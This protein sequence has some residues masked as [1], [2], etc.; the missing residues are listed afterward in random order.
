M[1]IRDRQA[2][3]ALFEAE[4]FDWYTTLR[5]LPRCPDCQSDPVQAVE[6]NTLGLVH[7]LECARRTGVKQVVQASTN[8][9]MRTRRNSPR[10]KP[11]SIRRR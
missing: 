11:P 6:V 10:W 1:D 5:V 2:I 4:K 9:S 3:P 7:L 8:A